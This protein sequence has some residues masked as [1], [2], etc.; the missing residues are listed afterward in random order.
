MCEGLLPPEILNK[1]LHPSD[2]RWNCS[3]GGTC[4]D[5]YT[6]REWREMSEGKYILLCSVFKWHLPLVPTNLPFHSLFWDVNRRL[7]VKLQ[8]FTRFSFFPNDVSTEHKENRETQTDVM[9]LTESCIIF[10]KWKVKDN[11]SK[12]YCWWHTCKEHLG[13][14]WHSDI[15][16]HSV[17]LSGYHRFHLLQALHHLET[18]KYTH[19]FK[20]KLC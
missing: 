18:Q 12:V 8:T 20:K 19:I 9:L 1:D 2:S 7:C 3:F 17:Q 15:L 14:R 6:M 5:C 4:N 13:H 10:R 16:Y 11:Q